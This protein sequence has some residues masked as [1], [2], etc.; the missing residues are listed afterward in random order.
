MGW[1]MESGISNKKTVSNEEYEAYL[2]KYTPLINKFVWKAIKFH[3]TRGLQLERD[4]AWQLGRLALLKSMEEYKDDKNTKFMTFLWRGL[5]NQFQNIYSDNRRKPKLASIDTNIGAHR[6]MTTWP[7]FALQCD[8]KELK[9]KPDYDLFDDYYVQKHTLRD[10]GVE[11]GMSRQTV[12]NRINRF[13]RKN[14]RY[15]STE[16]CIVN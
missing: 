16:R 11:R 12:L 4:E 3:N 7:D 6:S 5:R 9:G 8:L 2:E 10:I 15:L 13:C 14:G 1:S